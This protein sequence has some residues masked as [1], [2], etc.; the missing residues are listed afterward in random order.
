MVIKKI[1]NGIKFTRVVIYRETLVDYKEK[2]WSFLGAFIGL[3][4]ISLLQKQS[5]NSTENL[6]LIGSFG[7][8]CVLVYGAIHSPL[9]QPRCLVGGHLVSALIG[10]TIAKLTPDGCWFAPPLA[11]AF[12]IIGMQF[13][14]T[15]HPPGGATSMI[16]TIGSEK[17][18]SLAIGTP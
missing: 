14:R 9:A 3:G 13:T 15:L 6:F 2:G 4:I 5:F 1:K 17:V 10:V 16:A 7:A 18:K 12:S 8:S 11:V